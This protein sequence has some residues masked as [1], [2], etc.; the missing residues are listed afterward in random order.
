MKPPMPTLRLPEDYVYNP[1]YFMADS[2]TT[3]HKSARDTAAAV[4]TPL[5]HADSDASHATLPSS[6][7]LH[8]PLHFASVSPHT[9]PLRRRGNADRLAQSPTR[10][11]EPVGDTSLLRRAHALAQEVAAWQTFQAT[12]EDERVTTPAAPG[13]GSGTDVGSSRSHRPTRTAQLRARHNADVVEE[14]DEAARNIFHRPKRR[15]SSATSLTSPRV[16][17]P[18]VTD[19][20]GVFPGSAPPSFGATPLRHRGSVSAATIRSTKA[21]ELRHRH[22]LV[23]LEEMAEAERQRRE[24]EGESEEGE[25]MAQTSRRSSKH[26]FTI[27]E[28]QTDNEERHRR[29]LLRAGRRE[30]VHRGAAA[31]PTQRQGS[32]A[33]VGSREEMKAS[34]FKYLDE[35]ERQSEGHIN[36]SVAAVSGPT[37]GE[38]DAPAALPAPKQHRKHKAEVAAPP[39]QW[40]SSPPHQPPLQRAADAMAPLSPEP[41]PPPPSCVLTRATAVA[42]VAHSRVSSATSAATTAR[43]PP[44]PSQQ[45]QQHLHPVSASNGAAQSRKAAL[46]LRAKKAQP[47]VTAAPPARQASAGEKD[48]EDAGA[49]AVP[50]PVKAAAAAS[51]L[52]LHILPTLSP[53]HQHSRPS[54]CS[55]TRSSSS[56]ASIEFVATTISRAQSS[57]APSVGGGAG[58]GMADVNGG[59][60]ENPL[61]EGRATRLS[62]PQPQPPQQPQATQKA[63]LSLDREDAE[64][65]VA[66]TGVRPPHTAATPERTPVKAAVVASPAPVPPP[67]LSTLRRGPSVAQAVRSSSCEPT[68]Q[69]AAAAAVQEEEKTLLSESFV[70]LHSLHSHDEAD[71]LLR[72]AE[73]PLHH[74]PA[75]PVAVLLPDV[76]PAAADGAATQAELLRYYRS[77]NASSV[78]VGPQQAVAKK[79]K[80]LNEAAAGDDKEHGRAAASKQRA[81]PQVTAVE[82]M[83]GTT[84]KVWPDC[85]GDE[86]SATLLLTRYNSCVRTATTSARS[87]T[88]TS[89]TSPQSTVRSSVSTASTS[90][91]RDDAVCDGS[92]G[93]EPQQD[94]HAWLTSVDCEEE[95]EPGGHPASSS[96]ILLDGAADFSC[97]RHPVVPF[98]VSIGHD[99]P[100]STPFYDPGSSSGLYAWGLPVPPTN[101]THAAAAWEARQ[102][103]ASADQSSKPHEQSAAL[104]VSRRR[105]AVV[106]PPLPPYEPRME[107]PVWKAALDTV[108]LPNLQESNS[109]QTAPVP[110]LTP[111]PT[112]EEEPKEESARSPTRS[113]T[114]RPALHDAL[115]D[116]T[117]S[118][119]HACA[120]SVSSIPSSSAHV[121]VEHSM[122]NV[123]KPTRTSRL[124]PRTRTEAPAGAAPPQKISTAFFPSTEGRP[125]AVGAT[126]R[127]GGGVSQQQRC[128]EESGAAVRQPRCVAPIAADAVGTTLSRPPQPPAAEA[129]PVP[130]PSRGEEKA[131]TAVCASSLPSFSDEATPPLSKYAQWKA[132]QEAQR[133]A[134][135]AAQPRRREE[136]G[137]SRAVQNT[138]EEEEKSPLQRSPVQSEYVAALLAN[139]YTT[140]TIP[141]AAPTAVTSDAP[142]VL[143]STLPTLL[144]S[145]SIGGTEAERTPLERS[146]VGLHSGGDSEDG[147]GGEGEGAK[148]PLSHAPTPLPLRSPLADEAEQAPLTTPVTSLSLPTAVAAAAEKE[149]SSEPSSRA[150]SRSD[151]STRSFSHVAAAAAHVVDAERVAGR[152]ATPVHW[153]AH[154][155]EGHSPEPTCAKDE[156]EKAD[157]GKGGD[158]DAAPRAVAATAAATTVSDSPPASAD[159]TVAQEALPWS[160]SG[161]SCT[162]SPTHLHITAVPTA[163]T[164]VALD[165]EEDGCC[166]PLRDTTSGSRSIEQGRSEQESDRPPTLTTPHALF[167]RDS[168]SFASTPVLQSNSLSTSLARTEGTSASA[169]LVWPRGTEESDTAAAAAAAE[170]E[171]EEPPQEPVRPRDV[172]PHGVANGAPAALAPFR[173]SKATA[174]EDE[175][176]PSPY[177]PSSPVPGSD[178]QAVRSLLSEEIRW[179]GASSPVR[180]WGELSPGSV[181][182]SVPEEGLDALRGISKAS[183]AAPITRVQ[184]V[185]QDL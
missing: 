148:A 33:S 8:R 124:P 47:E 102:R 103:T 153:M 106:T 95:E 38:Y 158:D 178:L 86:E 129:S 150:F 74:L 152:A 60:K 55:S 132:K 80:G 59:E 57:V 51:A 165:K 24:E 163:A 85:A 4:T 120:A 84:A 117:E 135:A 70:S 155:A 151:A 41:R 167:S 110:A 183:Q 170:K 32:L 99:T 79:K 75:A 144:G 119:L 42:A 168:S 174:T 139:M 91:E 114:L 39:P 48:E 1:L 82:E 177:R 137:P 25:K 145:P 108:R 122:A 29:T 182:P 157:T 118:A 147:M 2:P 140:T 138:E 98:I 5:T 111:P 63:P 171:G 128:D 181:V 22:S 126:G 87:T 20:A 52:P 112:R 142:S 121:S 127:G 104:Q 109:P 164:A 66:T 68:S 173:T 93:D 14:R 23:L 94:F 113:V 26:I 3:A 105:S 72:T 12:L 149:A 179:S 161:D 16:A 180:H 77:A 40:D 73:N 28:V 90:S 62:P 159:V 172:V 185:H 58:E 6:T 131:E 11:P 65:A 21:V 61:H 115:R 96:A 71:E 54:S 10:P 97:L 69:F 162:P 45:Q 116:A 92:D 123:A 154:D 83:A 134:A 46:P 107:G 133:G 13:S 44:P 76:S 31:T 15:T 9:T 53:Q 160:S 64:I 130:T 17:P 49:Q 7:Y 166:T 100:R 184:Y 141:A 36:G 30:S 56:Y 19:V 35:Q 146:V 89:S 81:L 34:V 143:G 50:S 136:N 67:T 169:P 43:P 27:R 78:G 37:N 175:V 125:Y 88:P 18:T 101:H 176:I 156:E